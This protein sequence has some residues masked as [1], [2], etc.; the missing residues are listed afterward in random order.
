[1]AVKILKM[2]TFRENLQ[3]CK[4]RWGLKPPPKPAIRLIPVILIFPYIGESLP[5]IAIGDSHSFMCSCSGFSR[6]IRGG[7]GAAKN[8]RRNS[9]VRQ[10]LGNICQLDVFS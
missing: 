7:K 4:N 9:C 3:K 8:F 10:I 5:V 6:E 2:P 1:M